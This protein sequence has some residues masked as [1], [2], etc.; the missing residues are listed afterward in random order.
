V[1]G[2]ERDQPGIPH[3][4]DGVELVKPSA[5]DI[6]R[7]LPL[8]V[9]S[10]LPMRVLYGISDLLCYV[11]YHWIRYRRDVVAD[12][13]LQSFPEKTAAARK[14]IE[15]AFY[16]HFCDIAFEAV[17]VLT[18]SEKA[19][20][21]RLVVQNPEIVRQYHEQGRNIILYMG[22]Y[23]NWE[24]FAI[25]PRIIPHLFT[26]F[27]QPLRNKYVDKLMKITRCRFG[28]YMVPSHRGY[29]SI[30]AL[31]RQNLLTVTMVIG[32]QSP[33]PSSPKH[34][35]PFLHRE[36]AF[37]IGADRIAMKSNAV[38]IFP[39]FSKPRRGVYEIEFILIEDAA[40]KAPEG[41]IV[42][43]YASILEQTIRKAPEMWLW[44]HKRWKLSKPDNHDISK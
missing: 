27:Y 17:K 29:K 13:L 39:A 18:M 31:N 3:L 25:L 7:Y 35:T 26:S 42:E 19:F 9:L 32:D 8:Y 21:K 5:A 6:L 36:T 44:S 40:S 30:L 43:A 20:R 14:T 28:V 4:P 12:N 24:W 10:L 38:V 1:A 33:R 2:T 37:L 34:W 16:R 11:L 22:H 15:K 23:G 41:S